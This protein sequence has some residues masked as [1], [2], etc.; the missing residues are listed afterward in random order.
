MEA[1]R[2]AHESLVVHRDLKPSNVLVTDPES[3]APQVKLLDFG[4]AKL[5]DDTLPVTQPRTQT[6]HRLLTPAY[7]APEQLAGDGEVSTRTDVY[8][9]GAL[10]YEVLAGTQPFD[11]SDKSLTEI[12]A[13]VAEDTPPKPSERATEEGVRETDLQGDLDVILRKALRKE[14]DRRYRSV[15]AFM[16]DL[17]RYRAGEPVHAQPATATYRARKFLERNAVAVAVAAGFV[18]LAAGFL[19]FHIHQI[20][21]ERN[22]AQREAQKAEQVSAYLTDLLQSTRPDETAGET[23]TA[24]DMLERGRRRINQLD[25]QPAVQARMLQLLGNAHRERGNY[26]KAAGLLRRSLNLRDS[27]YGRNHRAVANTLEELGHVQRQRERYDRADSLFRASLSIQRTVFGAASPKLWEPLNNMG[28]AAEKQGN[29]ARAD[30]LYRTALTA[31][32][33]A[34]APDTGKLT[35]TLQNRAVLAHNRGQ[36]ETADSLYRRVL[37]LGRQVHDAPHPFLATVLA[38]LGRLHSGRGRY[39]AADS[40]LRRS[41]V[42]QRAVYNPPHPKIASALDGLAILRVRQKRLGAADSLFRE[43]VAMKRQTLG[44][45]HPSTGL[46]IMNRATVLKRRGQLADAVPLYRTARAIFRDALPSHHV[47]AAHV[48]AKLGQVLAALDRYSAAVSSF[49]EALDAY[50]RNGK[51]KR[52]REVRANLSDLYTEWGKPEKAA[53]YR[54]NAEASPA[55]E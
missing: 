43:A 20:T 16:E 54:Q 48:N 53:T 33:T 44:A 47:R 22:R 50:R 28:I 26:E 35:N 36:L 19:A 23:V 46:S 7:A 18:L 37:A 6:G 2:A 9:L 24:E 25:D 32:R 11:L 8:Q 51:E 29:Y 31:A 5:L 39:A 21:E 27:L 42:M 40:V 45:Q 13:V 15:G 17:R 30:S 52:V 49:K 55:S 4:I 41:V 12:E 34:A 3:G 10:A 38:N 14:P 1:V